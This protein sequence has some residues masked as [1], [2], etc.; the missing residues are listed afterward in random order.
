MKPASPNLRMHNRRK[1]R[2][3]LRVIHRHRVG[4]LEFRR[5]SE[6][7][8]VR[9]R[10]KAILGWIDVGGVRTPL[11]LCDLDPGKLRKAAS[12]NNAKNTYYYDSVTVDP[13][14]EELGPVEEG[15]PSP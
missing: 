1:V 13:R 9:G 8:F 12:G 15:S 6:L 5:V 3:G 4:K 7:V 2:L 14:Y 10:P 11:F